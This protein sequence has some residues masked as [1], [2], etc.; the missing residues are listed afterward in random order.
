R[1]YCVYAQ[2]ASMLLVLLKIASAEPPSFAEWEPF[3][4]QAGSG[5]TPQ[6]PVDFGA[7]NDFRNVPI[8]TAIGSVAVCAS[9]IAL[10]QGSLHSDWSAR[11]PAFHIFPMNSSVFRTRG[12]LSTTTLPFAST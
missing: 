7:T 5:T 6:S 9:L 11:M 8:H 3:G 2:A 12:S 1:W 4:V 10:Y